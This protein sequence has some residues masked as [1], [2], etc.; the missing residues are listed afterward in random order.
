[1]RGR[2]MGKATTHR[3]RRGEE[4]WRRR[5]GVGGVGVRVVV[6]IQCCH[7]AL[8]VRVPIKILMNLFGFRLRLRLIC[9]VPD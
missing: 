3:R 5:G 1:M 2:R 6:E 8:I 4:W 7:K 9:S